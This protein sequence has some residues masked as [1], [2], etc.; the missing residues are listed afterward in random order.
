MASSPLEDVSVPQLVR[1]TRRGAPGLVELSYT[2]CNV[3]LLGPTVHTAHF[4]LYRGYQPSRHLLSALSLSLGSAYYGCNPHVP[5]RLL[6]R[7]PPLHNLDLP[8]WGITH[9]PA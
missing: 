7:V 9:R 1:I 5:R 4:S 6:S 2:Q 8:V 3:P